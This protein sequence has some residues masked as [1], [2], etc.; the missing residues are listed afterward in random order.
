MV[1]YAAHQTKKDDIRLYYGVMRDVFGEKKKRRRS[2]ANKKN[3]TTTGETT[4]ETSGDVSTTTT[5]A[6][7]KPP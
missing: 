6:T 7:G 1:A 4:G 3:L 2:E 5:T